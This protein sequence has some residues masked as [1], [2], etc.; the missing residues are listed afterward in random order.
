MC[1]FHWLCLRNLRH[2]NTIF[3]HRA[4]MVVVGSPHRL[5]LSPVRVLLLVVVVLPLL[6][7]LLQLLLLATLL[8]VTVL[9]STS[10]ALILFTYAFGFDPKIDKCNRCEFRMDGIVFQICEIIYV[11]DNKKKHRPPLALSLC[12]CSFYSIQ[13]KYSSNGFD[14]ATHTREN[15]TWKERKFSIEHF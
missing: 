1:P 5:L 10:Y 11:G 2:R 12:L 9:R 3:W 14:V 6:L 7:P 15:Q 8:A 13:S 4:M